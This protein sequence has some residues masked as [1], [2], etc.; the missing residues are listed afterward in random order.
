MS[1][2][3]WANLSAM[4]GDNLFSYP[5]S[6]AFK[7]EV[8]QA[9]DHVLNIIIHVGP[10]LLSKSF[11]AVLKVNQCVTGLRRVAADDAKFVLPKSSI[12]TETDSLKKKKFSDSEKGWGMCHHN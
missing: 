2:F 3:R 4:W 9:Y 12:T 5:Y 1:V 11:K 6:I 8:S 10:L 7:A